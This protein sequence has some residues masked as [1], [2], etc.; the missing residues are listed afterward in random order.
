MGNIS[1]AALRLTDDQHAGKSEF[2]NPHLK[3]IELVDDIG[4]DYNNYREP[5]LRASYNL[6]G[7]QTTSRLADQ[8]KQLH[9]RSLDV[10]S[11]SQVYIE[12]SSLNL[13]EQGLSHLFNNELFSDLIIQLTANQD[14]SCSFH[15]HRAI[16]LSQL[17]FNNLPTETTSHE[18]HMTIQIIHLTDADV[19]IVGTILSYVYG[20]KPTFD[21]NIIAKIYYFSCLMSCHGLLK[22]SLLFIS[23]LQQVDE[24]I[25]VYESVVT[26]ESTSVFLTDAL[27]ACVQSLANIFSSFKGNQSRSTNTISKTA[28]LKLL[29]KFGILKHVCSPDLEIDFAA[30]V[31]LLMS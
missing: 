27:L 3:E 5:S 26:L 6:E 25:H 2:E 12:G 9:R 7:I 1:E 24:L 13:F 11:H 8:N 14:N 19:E 10:S 31:T 30:W 20:I 22:E 17:N 18:N 29:S 16:V 28:L 4:F 23:Q 21:V 15:L